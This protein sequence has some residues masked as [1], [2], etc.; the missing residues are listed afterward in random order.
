AHGPAP[1]GRAEGVGRV[2]DDPQ[3]VGRGQLVEAVV[4]AQ[5][6]AVVHGD[7]R[8]GALGH[9]LGRPGRVDAQGLVVDV[10][11]HGPAAGDDDG[12]DVGQVGERR[13]DDLVALAYAGHEHAHVEGGEAGAQRDDVAVGQPERL[14]DALLE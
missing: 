4:V 5:V 3:L 9:Q 10:A 7:D 14:G 12:L 6:A 1:V 11:Q 13:D 8:P 2:V